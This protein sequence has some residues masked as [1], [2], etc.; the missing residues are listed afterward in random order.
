[1][2]AARSLSGFVLAVATVL[3]SSPGFAD[4]KLGP[5]FR[6]NAYTTGHQ[7]YPSV[8]PLEGGG[9]VAVWNGFHPSDLAAGIFGQRFDAAGG[10]DGAEFHVNTYTT[11]TQAGPSVARDGSGFVVVWSS[12]DEVFGQRFDASGAP[13][14]TEFQ[15]N[16]YTY[17]SQ[18]GARVSGSGSGGFVVVWEGVVS[19]TDLGISGRVFDSAGA[20]LSDDFTVALKNGGV[21]W[22]SAARH[23]D[24]SFVVV[25]SDSQPSSKEDVFARR[26]DASG[27]PLADAFRVNTYSTNYQFLPSVSAD[28]AGGFVVVWMS[29]SYEDPAHTGV[30]G[31]RFG[32]DGAPTGGEFRVTGDLPHYPSPPTVGHDAAGGFMVIWSAYVPDEGSQSGMYGRRYDAQGERAGKKVR[33]STCETL[34]QSYP[35]IATLD[36]GDFVVAW[37]GHDASFDYGIHGQR[38]DDFLPTSRF[39]FGRAVYKAPE[40]GSSITVEVRRQG[41]TEGPA[42]VAYATSDGSATA[43]RDYRASSGTLTFGNGKATA[44]FRVALKPDTVLEG[45]ETINLSLSNPSE[46][47]ALALGNARVEID[48][49]DGAAVHL[50]SARHSRNEGAGSLSV[51]V[52]RSG[53]LSS[54]VSV[55]LRT[56]PET[57]TSP[58]DYQA[59]DTVVQLAAGVASKAVAVTIFDEGDVEGDET[60]RLQLSA[61]TGAALGTQ[62]S[63]V[64]TL[65]E[66]DGPCFSVP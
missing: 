60:F 63:A 37:R 64:V 38:F 26:Y 19:Y 7:E 44:T 20:P 10:L 54:A 23:G 41:S 62:R 31:Q 46:G 33:V 66:D 9:F 28:P 55:R 51:S 61:P 15:V 29:D 11:G 42:S 65:E 22:P 45:A 1:M 8:A 57:A 52:R 34:D 24:G 58:A 59:V 14:G 49:D 21:S 30:F 5:E 12:G 50:G 13:A 56:A 53:P 4:T 3:P 27:T 35:D 18:S 40:S 36:G 47:N 2:S 48:D 43:T 16:T 32:A 39:G 17:G 6:V 25:W